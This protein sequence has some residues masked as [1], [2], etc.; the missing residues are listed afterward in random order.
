MKR[1][2]AV[3]IAASLLLGA[4]PA[5]AET[6]YEKLIPDVKNRLAIPE[7][8][9]EF[10][11]SWINESESGTSYTFEW[12]APDKED[13]NTISLT[14]D[15]AG[16]VTS[17][18]RW[19]K[20]DRCDYLKMDVETAKA[21]AE[22]FAVSMVP[23]LDGHIRLE[24]STGNWGSLTFY[25]YEE[26]GGI[27]YDNAI[28]SVSVTIDDDV[29]DASL[30]IIKYSDEDVSNP[31]TAEE[32]YTAY[33]KSAEPELVY[34]FYTDEDENIKTFPA[35][36]KSADAAV[37]AVTGE[38]V[39]P[40]VYYGGYLRAASEDMA[41]GEAEAVNYKSLTESE[42]KETARLQ[43][44]I[45]S[46]DAKNRVRAVTGAALEEFGDISLYTD[47]KSG[48]Y[49]LYSSEDGVYISAEVD[50]ANADILSLYCGGKDAAPKLDEY[51][52][53]D[54][55][56]AEKLLNEL[57]P[58]N[59][60]KLE[61]DAD[62]AER[63]AM[64]INAGG[65][66]SKTAQACF[67]FKVNGIRVC[68]AGASLSAESD[69][70]G[71]RY[72]L[73]VT[74]LDE[75]AAAEYASPEDFISASE[76]LKP[77]DFRLRY[78]MTV[79][80]ADAESY[81]ADSL[82][83]S[84]AARP[85][86]LSSLARAVYLTDDFII[87]AKSGKRVNYRGEETTDN[88]AKYVYSDIANHWVRDAAERLALAGIGFDGGKLLPD[89]PLKAEEMHGLLGKHYYNYEKL[90][91]DETE[92]ITR[93]K[94]AKQLAELMGCSALAGADIFKQP[95]SDTSEDFGAVAILKGYGIVAADS[96]TF[97]PSDAITRA[98]FLQ[99]LYNTLVRD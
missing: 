14:C 16:R 77:S 6:D 79:S 38:L 45:S 83:R 58:V 43:G 90:F 39:E 23:E 13:Y 5:A 66:G 53:S 56:S 20:A 1:T 48:A 63:S 37:S 97:R 55:N 68:D 80:D 40:G 84:V 78:I 95:Y 9:S 34:R 18:H 42:Q 22:A 54:P 7:E 75:I 99:M 31:I 67:S 52:L 21:K 59:A 33:F 86:R 72:S 15:E 74:R 85:P 61:Y 96:A 73:S 35:Y 93:L 26:N 92:P 25:V 12:T 65:D 88:T 50:A 11:C 69:A 51:D 17:Y 10:R 81:D 71:T 47:K 19:T 49:K 98:E 30:D 64:P 24:E 70:S 62:A 28:G 3:F 94:A 60:A 32:A 82:K 89:E 76:A 2:I 91:E 36:I 44:Y 4:L 46:E 27:E 8:Y 29:S 41:A 87:H 57:A